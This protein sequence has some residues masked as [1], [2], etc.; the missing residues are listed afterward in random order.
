[1][2]VSSMIYDHYFD[3][4]KNIHHQPIIPLHYPY[5][6]P[7]FTIPTSPFTQPYI[8]EPVISSEEIKELK[9]LLEKARK[10][11][12]EHNQKECELQSKKDR[13]IELAKQLG[14]EINFD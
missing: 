7:Y 10:Y 1:M 9:D 5:P 4:W 8:T 2:C 13:L 6:Q 14:V 12:K 11:D 3:K